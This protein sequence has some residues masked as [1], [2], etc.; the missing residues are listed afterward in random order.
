M[1]FVEFPTTPTCRNLLIAAC[2]FYAVTLV[3]MVSRIAS[4]MVLSIK[5]SWEDVFTILA[6]LD[7]TAMLAI[8]TF[9]IRSGVGYPESM[10][11]VNYAFNGKLDTVQPILYVFGVICARLGVFFFYLRAFPN[12]TMQWATK[13]LL[14][15][16][17]CLVVA[18]ALWDI[19]TCQPVSLNWDP[20]VPGTCED[21]GPTYKAAAILSIAT[22]MITIIMPL[23]LIWRLQTKRQNKINLSCLFA[24]GLSTVSIASW[25]LGSLT[26]VNSETRAVIVFT[27]IIE[28][29]LIIICAS[30]PIIYP[31]IVRR[32]Q[33]SSGI[34]SRR[35]QGWKER[36]TRTF[37]S[38]TLRERSF[39]PIHNL[40][41]PGSANFELRTLESDPP[42]RLDG[43]IGV[44]QEWSISSS[45]GRLDD[46]GNVLRV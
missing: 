23:P 16:S 38:A 2:V 45:L 5:L 8:F 28:I 21:R 4:R 15:V 36:M 25:R 41:G 10:I 43:G 26:S 40:S 24:F 11:S 18:I 31:L 46:S 6:T 32:R 33:K 34:V 13:I 29:D 17:T 30:L 39:E 12:R 1:D 27:A 3:V 7:T 42:R 37:G 22:D 14:V 19:F 9:S 44:T 20:T 35:V